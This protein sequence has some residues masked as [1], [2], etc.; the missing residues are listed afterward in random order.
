[1]KIEIRQPGN[2][3]LDVYTK[4]S[5]TQLL[6]YDEPEPG[7]FIAESEK[8]LIRAL[9]AGYEP[10]SLLLENRI[11]EKAD[12]SLIRRCE[13]AFYNAG[14]PA[15]FPV[16]TADYELMKQM[17]GYA[18]TG[19]VL[20]AMH[21]KPLPSV[22]DI[23]TGARRIAVLE[24]V[25]NPA[26]IGAIFRSAA[27]LSID[28]V[29]LTM[30]C[31]DPLYRRS[32]RVSMGNVFLVPWTYL[33]P[34]RRRAGS[35]NHWEGIPDYEGCAPGEEQDREGWPSPWLNRLKNMG[36]TTAAMALEE[37]SVS[38]DDP[39]L[40]EA[41]RIA[42]LLGTEGDGLKKRTIAGCDYTVKI[43]MAAGV[44]SLNV[45]A[46]SAVAFW[47]IGKKFPVKP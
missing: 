15:P 4:L 10:I 45:A 17:V 35:D 30:A 42:I 33:R 14:N 34:I 20:C 5:E 28:A 27:A 39:R 43:P 6:R 46:A 7:I 31:C 12:C 2:P 47:E 38:I 29:L 32:V 16:Y 23:C 19:G 3:A 9:D 24:N 26:N 22:S 40:K 11:A 44:D 37:E 13:E 18:L 21:R 41:E 25:V 1:M 8:V 36:F